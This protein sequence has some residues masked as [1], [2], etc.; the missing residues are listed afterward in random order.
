MALEKSIKI[1]EVKGIGAS[2]G[3]TIGKAF[4]VDKGK[5][6]IPKTKIHSD[7]VPIEVAKFYKCID[8]VIEEIQQTKSKIEKKGKE[9]YKEELLIIDMQLLLLNDSMISK[10]TV[11]LIRDKKINAEWALNISL[12]EIYKK[13]E[14]MDDYYIA[15]RQE[16]IKHVFREVMNCL[17][18]KRFNTLEEIKK[19]VILIGHDFSPAETIKMNF[20]KVKGFIT[21]VGSKTSHTAIIARSQKIPSIVGVPN[22]TDI[23]NGGDDIILDGYTG[24]VYIN[25][26]YD[27]INKFKALEDQ[28]HKFFAGLMRDKN[29]SA[30]TRDGYKVNIYGNIEMPQELDALFEYGGEGIGLFRTE[31]LYLSGNTLPTEEEHF[32]VYKSVAEKIYPRPLVIRTIDIGGD[33]FLPGYNE[34]DQLNPAMGLRAVRFCLKELDIFKSQIKGLIRATFLFDNIKILIPMV[35]GIN[36]I[37]KVKEI[38]NLCHKELNIDNRDKLKRVDIGVMVEIPSSA[39]LADIFCQYVDFFSIGTNDLIQYT[40]AIDRLNKDVSY[41]YEPAHPGVLRLIELTIKTAKKFNIP[42]AMCGEMAGEIMYI[43]I[44][45][46]MGIESLS[47][48]PASIPLVKEIIC[49][50]SLKESKKIYNRIKK[51]HTCIEIEKFLKTELNSKFPNLS[52]LF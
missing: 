18:G 49:N 15:E 8:N 16:D 6:K 51:L 17:M 31:Y 35:S 40:L 36:E 46:A 41:L 45:L 50:L 42:V 21:E 4:L 30:V 5:L 32:K 52:F 14:N 10:K 43:P 13:F 12:D 24:S 11:E 19:P 47:M 38:I 7:K 1:S 29:R 37:I 44:L 28:Y 22:I 27:T 23:V 26:S 2:F 39:I 33:K 34:S 3:I 9:L 48:N 20:K 25:P